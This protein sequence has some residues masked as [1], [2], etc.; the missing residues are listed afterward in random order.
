MLWPLG[1]PVQPL[2]PQDIRKANITDSGNIEKCVQMGLFCFTD[3]HKASCLS[4]Q[5]Y[6]ANSTKLIIWKYVAHIL[7]TLNFFF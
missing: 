4:V 5:E 3:P 6:K 7:S 2:Q 1:H